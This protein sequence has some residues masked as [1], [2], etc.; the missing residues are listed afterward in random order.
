MN[1]TEV[2]IK[3]KRLFYLLRQEVRCWCAQYPQFYFAQKEKLYGYIDHQRMID[4]DTEIVIDGY[5][6]SANTFA[7]K[8]F[9]MAQ[10]R[11]VQ[12]GH[13]THDPS[14]VIAAA[15]ANIPTIVLIRNPGEVVLSFAARFHD[16]SN[17]PEREVAKLIYYLLSEYI[18]FY[19]RIIKYK[20]SY[21]V[22]EF[23]KL[24]SSYDSIIKQ[25]NHKYG[26]SFTPFYCD[27]KNVEQVFSSIDKD[28]QKRLGRFDE[29]I[30]A[31]PSSKRKKNKNHLRPYLN[32]PK[33]SKKLQIS[34]VLYDEI[35]S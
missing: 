21:V 14:Q 10:V 1:L 8:A 35:I 7:E 30:V 23:K 33:I 22:A 34:Y 13:H 3:P 20:K 18:V 6:C 27:E 32:Q 31:R 16:I 29:N 11:A 15:T 26:V 12:I 4:S 19:R 25:V 5:P 9:R 2:I 24:T 17:K 28:S